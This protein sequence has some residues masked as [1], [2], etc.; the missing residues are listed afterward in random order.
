MLR[1]QAL[2]ARSS[3]TWARGFAGCAILGM[4]GC[5]SHP[6]APGW[7]TLLD[8]AKP[9]TLENWNRVGFDNWR[10]EDGAIVAASSP[11]PGSTFLAT[12]QAYGDFEV[13][14]QVWVDPDTNSGIFLRCQHPE[15]ISVNSCYEM[16]IWDNYKV[17]Y[18]ATGS[19]A[20]YAK[21]DPVPKAGN[22]WSTF[23]I[24]ARGGHIQVLMDGR[25][26]VELD[27][28]TYTSGPI[29]LQWGGGGIVKWRKVEVRRLAP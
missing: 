13:R 14:A 22:K 29:G 24:T 6:A 17:Q 21:V 9:K 23:D 7:V 8:G 1:A 11:V 28:K 20:L 19:I 10:V 2:N 25:Q 12:K 5:A 4:G 18:Y 3:R 27:D 15:A 26:T 16:N